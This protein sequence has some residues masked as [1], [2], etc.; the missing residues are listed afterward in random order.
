MTW[1]L[2]L[3][4]ALLVWLLWR[5]PVPWRVDA[6]LTTIVQ[7]LDE[8]EAQQK[9]LKFRQYEILSFVHNAV[10]EAYG[11]DKA[12]AM[13]ELAEQVATRFC[14]RESNTGADQVL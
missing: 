11:T 7:K 6:V 14:Q 12:N 4:V 13:E 1:I 2:W 10:A 3:I 5:S 8:I 9:Q